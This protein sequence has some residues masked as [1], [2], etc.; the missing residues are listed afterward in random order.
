MVFFASRAFR[1]RDIIKNVSSPFFCS[2]RTWGFFSPFGPF[3][4]PK[5]E[6][7][8]DQRI[9]YRK[10]SCTVI[11]FGPSQPKPFL[12]PRPAA[13]SRTRQGETQRVAQNHP[14][15]GPQ[16]WCFV[17]TGERKRERKRESKSGFGPKLRFPPGDSGEK[18][19]EETTCG[20][21]LLTLFFT[22]R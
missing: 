4:W 18:V 9:R 22:P 19:R 11:M 13:L 8:Q 20:E 6:K 7:P 2:V 17:I 14:K 15:T 21:S 12:S 5:G 1:S 3:I 10:G 16:F